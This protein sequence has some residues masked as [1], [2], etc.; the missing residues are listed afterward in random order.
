M[1]WM[2]IWVHPYTV[3][4]VQVGV[5]FENIYVG[6]DL[7]DV[8]RSWLRLKTPVDCIP[9][10]CHMYTMSCSTLISCGWEYGST[11]TLLRLCRWEWSLGKMGYG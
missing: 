7:S 3:T 11:L 6:L 5:D 1:M 10:P 9:H 2:G 4:L 8:V